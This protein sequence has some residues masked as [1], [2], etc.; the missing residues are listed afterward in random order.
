MRNYQ[1]FSHPGHAE[2]TRAANF[3]R[4]KPNE[5][6]PMAL[7]EAAGLNRM[8]SS[9]PY[10]SRPILTGIAHSNNL[11]P[12]SRNSIGDGHTPAHGDAVDILPQIWPG[13]AAGWE[14]A[15]LVAMLDDRRDKGLGSVWVRRF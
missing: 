6:R 10:Q 12:V 7:A 13:R 14:P 15:Q 4:S 1:A 11:H 3:G 9:L 8:S 5:F 2:K